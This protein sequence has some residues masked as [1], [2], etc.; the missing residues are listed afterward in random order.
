MVT[1]HHVISEAVTVHVQLHDESDMREAVVMASDERTDLALLRL[2]DPWGVSYWMRLGMSSEAPE[3]GTR[4]G[5]VGYPLGG[6]IGLEINYSQGIINS[7]RKPGAVRILQVDTGAGPGSSG[8]PLFRLEDG[9][10]IGVLSQGLAIQT[11]MHANFAV[12]LFELIQLGWLQ[13]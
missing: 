11:G 8:G 12:D 4:V 5:L 13:L 2:K 6:N 9:L 7:V 10:V 3:L 1:C